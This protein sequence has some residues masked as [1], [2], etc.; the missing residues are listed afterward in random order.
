ML[1]KEKVGVFLSYIMQVLIFIYIIMGIFEKN[2]LPVFEGTMALIITFLPNLLKR[3]WGIH[4][5]WT[6]NFLIVLSLYLHAE[7]RLLSFYTLFYPVYDKIGHFIGSATVALLGFSL[8]IILDKY[9]KIKLNKG[10][11]I[12][13][14]VIFA[15]TMGGLWEIIEFT[16]DTL[17]GTNHQPGLSDTMLDLIFDLLGGLFIALLTH[18]NFN[19]MKEH[20]ILKKLKNKEG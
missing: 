18:V 5:P 12:F 15:L 19:T 1:T 17:I 6:L 9:T 14:I 20:I 4:L 13:F 8:A 3:K 10:S 7:G 2:Y 11:L 16:S